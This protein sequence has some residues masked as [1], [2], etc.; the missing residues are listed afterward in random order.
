[1]LAHKLNF[2][3]DHSLK[4]WFGLTTDPDTIAEVVAEGYELLDNPHET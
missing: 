4:L 1:M 2:G 3:W